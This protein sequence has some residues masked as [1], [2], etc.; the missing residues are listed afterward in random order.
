ML[1]KAFDFLL[2][3]N[4]QFLIFL[5]SIVHTRI[6]FRRQDLLGITNT[7]DKSMKLLKKFIS[8]SKCF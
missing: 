4:L 6:K 7:Y 5:L 2:C 1:L 3:Q 8:Y